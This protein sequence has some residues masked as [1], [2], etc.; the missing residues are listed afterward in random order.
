[1]SPY[2]ADALLRLGQRE[3]S[4]GA[5]TEAI[6]HLQRLVLEHRSSSAAAEGWLW[7]GYAKIANNDGV[8]GCIALD[9]ARKRIPSTDVELLNRI[10][11]ITQSCRA[12]NRVAA[13]GADT[14]RKSDPTRTDDVAT[15]SARSRKD[16]APG[17]KY[18]VQVGAL[19]TKVEADRLVARMKEKGH[20]ARI[21]KTD[22]Y[23]VRIGSFQTR[24][25]AS[26]LV[27]TLKR[28][29]IDAIVVEVPRRGP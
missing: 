27:A 24:A 29:K 12:D 25:E 4:R 23:K 1:L 8:N 11:Y 13:A 28:E 20:T 3:Y 5:R 6:T 9:S 18:A 16:A 22:L 10:A 7:L 14:V 15:D 2:A 19:K 26:K 21:D 17:G